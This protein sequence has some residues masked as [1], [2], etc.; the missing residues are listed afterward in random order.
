MKTICM[1][2]SLII[3]SI[4]PSFAGEDINFK[5]VGQ[6][7]LLNAKN[8]SI[9]LDEIQGFSSQTSCTCSSES[10]EVQINNDIPLKMKYLLLQSKSK[11][12]GPNCWNSVQY[13][14]GFSPGVN[15]SDGQMTFWLNSPYCKEVKSLQFGDVIDISILDEVKKDVYNTTHSYIYLSKHLG[16]TKNGPSRDEP[17]QLSS[18]S[19]INRNYE[20]RGT[21]CINKNV[22]EGLLLGCSEITT[23]YRCKTPPVFSK[24]IDQI[25]MNNELNSIA[26]M[27]SSNVFNN[28]VRAETI[29]KKINELKKDAQRYFNLPSFNSL[30]LVLQ[31]HVRL[32]FD[33][34]QNDSTDYLN[35]ITQIVFFNSH[36][37]LRIPWKGSLLEQL[38]QNFRTS[39]DYKLYQEEEFYFYNKLFSNLN[40]FTAQQKY[41]EEIDI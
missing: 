25:N 38:I 18:H 26:T 40:D 6:D 15:Y 5:V 37:S 32:H 33:I 39:I 19:S 4:V 20:V 41:S 27:V 13:V 28:D 12:D 36:P 23:Y 2:L 14:K 34:D 9:L 7:I 21:D 29:Q 22:Q 30:P 11:V 10:C 35:Y 31:T 8:C 1:S 16:F 17:Y 3:A 24:T